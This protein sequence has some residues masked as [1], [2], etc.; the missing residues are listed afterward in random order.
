MRFSLA[1]LP[2][3]LLTACSSPNVTDGLELTQVTVVFSEL[4]NNVQTTEAT[5]RTRLNS[6]STI[7]R[8][9][10]QVNCFRVAICGIKPVARNEEKL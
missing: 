3:L 10:S 4:T 5:Q 6:T 1:L 9:H 2:V 7:C 8:Q